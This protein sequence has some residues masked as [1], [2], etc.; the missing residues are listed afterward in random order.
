MIWKR[1]NW[2]Y[3]V[4]CMLVVCFISYWVNIELVL[5]NVV[6]TLELCHYPMLGQGWLCVKFVLLSNV[7]PMVKPTLA[8]RAKIAGLTLEVAL[9]QCCIWILGN[10]GSR[11]MRV[12][13]WVYVIVQCMANLKANLGPM[14]QKVLAQR[15]KPMLTQ[16]WIQVLIQCWV[17][18]GRVLGLCYC[19]TSGQCSIQRWPNKQKSAG[20]T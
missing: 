7:G 8:Q 6:L 18:A 1:R 12:Y 10:V 14:S 17:K 5:S 9:T 19:Q 11:L 13:C 16:C 15:R 2:K 4:G 20:P 3:I